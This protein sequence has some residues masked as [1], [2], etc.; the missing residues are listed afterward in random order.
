MAS[1]APAMLDLLQRWALRGR[2]TGTSTLALAAL[3][4]VSIALAG[5]L[6]LERGLASIGPVPLATA[7]AISPIVVDRNGR[8]LRAFTTPQGRWRL[9]VSHA[10][11]DERYL[12]LLVAYED[13]RYWQHHGVDPLAV[14][15][16]GAQLVRNGRV[17]SG[18]STLTMQVARLL[19]QRH[20][21]TAAGKLAQALR[22]IQ[23]ERQL[24]KHQILDLYLRLAP[25]GGNIE[26]VR[27][28]SLA[29]FG[30][31]PQR[32]SIAEA[33]LLVALPQSP[34]ARRPDRHVA[35]ARAARDKVLARGVEAGV[36]SAAEAERAKSEAVPRR[37]QAFPMLAPHL[38]EAEV[39]AFP[40]LAVHRLTID[41]EVQSAMQA[42]ADERARLLGDK[43]TTAIIV[44]D[45]TTG[46]VLA[47]VGASDYLDPSRNGAIDMTAAVRSPGS[48]L[49]PIIYGLGFEAGVVHPETL[50]EDR[51][52][53]FGA[54]APENFEDTYR[55]TVSIREALGQSL[56]VPAVR[57]LDR[58]GPQHL[59][60]RLARAGVPPQLPEGAEPNLAIALGGLGLTLTQLTELYAGL[61]SGGG[62]L[63]LS[64][65]VGEGDQRRLSGD[66]AED[67]H[68]RLLGPVAAWYVTDILKDA[69]PPPNTKGGR[70]AYKTGTSY[71][72]RDALAIG[73]DGRFVIA[74]WAGRA[75]GAATPGLTGRT[76][77]APILFDAFGRLGEKSVPLAKAPRGAILASG[78][79]LPPPLRRFGR[80]PAIVGTGPFIKE[81]LAI[82]FPPDR[83]ELEVA[84]DGDAIL[85]KAEGGKL[86]LTWLIDGEPIRSDPHRREVVWQPAG[87]GFAKLSVIDAAG[88]ADRVTIRLR[89]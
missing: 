40:R 83:A 9:P 77:A 74:V 15:R 43:L 11:I 54:Y 1:E 47:H 71:G 89:Q 63:A 19:D 79:D 16:A 23:L 25:F 52:A 53:R 7:D 6:V 5:W 45:H 78:A 50:I 13:R 69:P 41:R 22:A 60:G 30:K 24:S 31:E 32:L 58:L 12:E 57:V 67:R 76:A 56:N 72:Y 70:I 39:A 27:A 85:L 21:R 80:L 49:K 48:T 51:P 66:V 29:Y 88:S 37:R 33:A 75:D 44:A 84:S 82:A 20:E 3:A 86:P 28:A 38:A 68:K 34:E 8:L 36:I 10:E 64:H 14:A 2:P 4:L 35:A 55:G 87:P 81:T 65:R 17:V 73:Y 61:A 46:E 42:L 59:V 18:A 26:G 62:R